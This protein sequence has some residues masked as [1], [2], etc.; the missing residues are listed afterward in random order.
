MTTASGTFSSEAIRI[1]GSVECDSMSLLGG[2]VGSRGLA[3][4]SS[5]SSAPPTHIK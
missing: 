5:M 4:K 2:I 3:A 1:G